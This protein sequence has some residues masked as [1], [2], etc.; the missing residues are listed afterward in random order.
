MKFFFL[1]SW[2]NNEYFGG[3]FW[4]FDGGE[5]VSMRGDGANLLLALTRTIGR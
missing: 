4:R 5:R 1:E 3:G 2:K